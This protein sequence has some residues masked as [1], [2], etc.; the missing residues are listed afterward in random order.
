MNRAL[1]A[2]NSASAEAG[3]MDACISFVGGFFIAERLASWTDWQP[4]K[5]MRASAKDFI[6]KMSCFMIVVSPVGSVVCTVRG[7]CCLWRGG[8]SH[9]LVVFPLSFLDLAI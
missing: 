4:D 5:K 2:F 9:E 7:D 3:V 1:P 6:F 8:G